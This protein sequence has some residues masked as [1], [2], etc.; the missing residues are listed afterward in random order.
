VGDQRPE[1]LQL[2][3]CVGAGHQFASGPLAA[4]RPYPCAPVVVTPHDHDQRRPQAR[5][6]P[7]QA[8]L[9]TSVC[10]PGSCAGVA[11]PGRQAQRLDQA[12]H[13]A[14]VA[15]SQVVAGGSGAL[16]EGVGDEG[17]LP[18]A[19][20]TGQ[21]HGHAF[22]LDHADVHRAH[23]ADGERRPQRRIVQEYLGP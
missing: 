10:G 22:D 17:G 5:Q 3:S 23:A 8:V 4:D 12:V 15:H 18:D 9:P 1:P 14:A 19:A 11:G 2:P 6:P 7:R 13:R 20:R 16:S 21:K